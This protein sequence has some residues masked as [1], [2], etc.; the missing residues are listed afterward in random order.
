MSFFDGSSLKWCMKHAACG[1]PNLQ[2][3][4]SL[5]SAFTAHISCDLVRIVLFE[6]DTFESQTSDTM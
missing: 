5:K 6:H 1:P 4:E 3:M 2:H